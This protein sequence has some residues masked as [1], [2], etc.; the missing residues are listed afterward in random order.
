MTE[1]VTRPERKQAGSASEVSPL[2]INNRKD[3]FGS[4]GMD[5]SRI[6]SVNNVVV[7]GGN[8]SSNHVQQWRY[9]HYDAI[10]KHS[11]SQGSTS[12][13][14]VGETIGQKFNQ[15]TEIN[16]EKEFAVFLEDGI[17]INFAD[18]RN[19]AEKLAMG[20]ISLGLRKG[21]R[22]GMWG[23]NCFEWLL[24]QYATS[25]AGMIM[26][27]IN[28]A[29]RSYEL[30]YA[31]NKVGCKALI[32]MPQ[33]K[34]SNYYEILTEIAPQLE[35]SQPGQL[36]CDEI[37][38]L[39]HVVL[40]E[41]SQKPGCFTL[42]EIMHL[43]GIDEHDMLQH[44]QSSLHFDE[45]INIQF[46]SGTTG[47]PKGATLTHHNILNN[48]SFL[49]Q[50]L[51]Y[52]Q[53][54]TKI[55]I[56]VPLYHCFGMVIG[57]LA[58]MISGATA[59]FPSRGFDAS[60]ALNAVH[61]EK[62]TAIYGTP[63]MFI[64]MLN[65]PEFGNY[66]FSLLR[67]GVMAGSQCPEEVMKQVIHKMNCKEITIVY[68]QTEASPITNITRRDDP[69][70]KR[71]SSVGKPFPATEVKIVDSRRRIVPINTPGELCFRGHGVM[72][73][74][75]GDEQKTEEVLDQN[76]WLYSGDLGMMDGD[77]YCE[78]IGRAKDMVIRGGENIYPKEI[79]E[80]L[81]THPM[82][83]DVQIIGV[84]DKRLGEEI[85]AWIRLH[86]Q[87][88]ASPEEIKEFC[89]GRISHFK[90]P[91]YIKFVDSYPL[92]VT[93]KVRKNEMREMMVQQLSKN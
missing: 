70:D 8:G 44:V 24:V 50:V 61:Y 52:Y 63:T 9:Q 77:G 38:E 83:K 11:Y 79:E 26:V 86:D 81:H 62:C 76:G 4:L 35:L 72:K 29:Y 74:Y 40:S 19:E 71:I 53:E 6:A 87:V 65:V 32:M 27:N 17:R 73:G 30:K 22:V 75:W 88:L 10:V 58:A 67:T 20:L 90:I 43:G 56:P 42:P 80:F 45:P 55:C 34:T 60:M 39:Q 46:T 7:P 68:G 25:F 3:I 12:R 14:L 41:G 49:C 69:I 57:S 85:A 37:P 47:S 31:L 13:P 59:V 54:N 15:I 89:R 82:I 36:N 21:D 51:D 33:F 64:D 92:T 1:D 48:A 91:K 28:P 2:N 78:I 84:P 23:A 66:N 16:P 93:G 18:F 5:I